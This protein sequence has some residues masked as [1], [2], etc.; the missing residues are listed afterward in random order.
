MNEIH[1]GKALLA[2]EASEARGTR[3]PQEIARQI[4]M[5]DH[6]RARWLTVGTLFLWSIAIGAMFVV[7]YAWYWMILPKLEVFGIDRLR[8]ASAVTPETLIEVHRTFI[9]A[10]RVTIAMLA[11]CVAFVGLAAAST[12]WLVGVSRK[13]TLRQINAEL[14][15]I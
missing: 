7:L 4:V 11:G 14:A 1:F 2:A 8:P 13:A 15:Q 5:R 9:M 10:Y 12:V 6:R 3:E